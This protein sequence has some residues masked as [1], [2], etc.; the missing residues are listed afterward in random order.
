MNRFCVKCGK[1]TDKLIDSLCISCYSEDKEIVDFPSEIL[2]DYDGRSDRIR[3]GSKWFENN[4]EN[5]HQELE[6]KLIKNLKTKR[7]EVNNFNVEILPDDY[8]LGVAVVSFDVV[9]KGVELGF[10]K[11]IEL[12][13][14]NTISD[15]SMKISSYYHEAIIQI[16]FNEK[17]SDEIQKKSTEEVIGYLKEHKKKIEL[18]HPIDIKKERGGYDILVGSKKAARIVAERFARKHNTSVVHSAKLIGNKGGK[19]VHR[20]TFCVRI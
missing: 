18:S 1:E 2:L 6:K 9:I 15:A 5:I 10:E 7:Q 20:H 4:L 3:F 17:V 13:A 14:R 19:E 12:K 8:I 11:K 16:R